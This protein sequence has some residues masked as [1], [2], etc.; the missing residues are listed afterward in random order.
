MVL[1]SLCGPADNLR[2]FA[3]ILMNE[4]FYLDVTQMVTAILH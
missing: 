1:I 2:F 4:K 3:I